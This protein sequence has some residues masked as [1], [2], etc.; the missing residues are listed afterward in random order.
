MNDPLELPLR[1]IHLPESVSMWPLAYGWWILLAVIILIG[2][3]AIFIYLRNKKRKIAAITL[4]RA[5]FL[6]IYMEYEKN[7][8]SLNFI[9]QVSI[10]FRRLSISLFPRTEV[11]SLT[12]DDWLEFLDSK[13][14]GQPFTQGKGRILID[15][16]YRQYIESDDVDEIIQHCRD[17]IGAVATLKVSRA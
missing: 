8:D 17:W 3:L 6:K 4:A 13:I 14:S 1:D 10:L 5:E 2:S 16:P 11:A 7:R 12:G 15:A 9:R